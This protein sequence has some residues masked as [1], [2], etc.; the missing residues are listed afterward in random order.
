MKFYNKKKSTKRKIAIVGLPNS[1]KSQTFNLL[2]GRY[3]VVANYPFTTVTLKKASS[4]YGQYLFEVIDSPGF[5]S[6]LVQS[7]EELLV[8]AMLFNEQ[9]DFL[10]QC[11]DANNLKQSLMLTA[12][13]IAL[14]IP[15]IISLHAVS[16][17][18]WKGITVS[19]KILAEALGIPVVERYH[20]HE[21]V[22]EKIF[23][24]LKQAQS[25]RSRIDYGGFIQ[26]AIIALSTMLPASVPYRQKTAQLCLMHDPWIFKE[27]EHII[28]TEQVARVQAKTNEFRRAYT[29]S[30]ALAM[31]Q[32]NAR[33][34]DAL[35]NTVCPPGNASYGN[36]LVSLG[37]LCRHP[38]WG[39]FILAG[40]LAAVFE[41]VVHGAAALSGL[42]NAV[43]TEPSVL[44]LNTHIA[45]PFL[46]DLLIGK[47]GMITIGFFNA[48]CTV[49]P[50]LGVFFII[51]GIL[52]DTGYIPNLCVLT[53]RIFGHIGITGRSLL[54]IVL[55]FG[56]KTMA[57]LTTRGLSSR[58]EK[59]IAI[60]LIVLAIPCSA[61]MGLNMAIL[62]SM[63]L[64]TFCIAFISLAIVELLAGLI[65]N[66]VIP[67]ET[68]TDFIQELPPVRLPGIKAITIK[69]WYRLFWF[70]KEAVPVF[71]LAAFVLF[72]PN[73]SGA[74]DSSK[75]FFSPVIVNWL[76]LPIDCA[77]ALLLT[78][79]RS[80]AG[81]AYI[82]TMVNNGT[83]NY[84]QSIIA[85]VVTT[86]FVP[87]LANVV[88]MCKELGIRTGLLIVGAVNCS[89]FLVGGILRWLLQ[90]AGIC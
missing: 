43:I 86:L 14:G 66:K 58:K 18:S 85:V 59:I 78:M 54:S 37:H 55:G 56:C 20:Q 49:L 19:K 44:F 13:L 7:E 40:I 5:H 80:E 48:L 41:S 35:Y 1:G 42:L 22:K 12:D 68:A 79:A 11:I 57:T 24:A 4:V 27:L 75:N 84:T 64:S 50:V 72:L 69:T 67:G 51:F 60:F 30:I 62:G 23:R 90:L 65:L 16:E 9:P 25:I 53:N 38:V 77:D 83:L 52:E 8:R 71:I 15:M 88:V 39:F 81:A 17:I 47:Y 87:C 89:A 70:L 63:G 32:R 6:L 28:G 74:L 34:V 82:L 26:Q 46:N 76:G 73:W 29:G 33:W 3:S 21:H 2:T 31:Q 45:S 10:I 61:Q 36:T